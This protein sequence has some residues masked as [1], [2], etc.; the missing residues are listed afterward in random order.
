MAS[1]R[2]AGRQGYVYGTAAR[3]MAAERERTRERRVVHYRQNMS[4][5]VRRN[6]EKALQMNLPY[7]VEE[8]SRIKDVPA[9]QIIEITNRNAKQMYRLSL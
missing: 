7:V 1:Y 3:D 2:A 4:H 8:I 6:Q 9:E 5:T